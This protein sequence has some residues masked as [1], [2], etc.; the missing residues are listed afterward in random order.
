MDE[1][2]REGTAAGRQRRNHVFGDITME[3]V[4]GAR[5]G[6]LLVALLGVFAAPS[7]AEET[8]VPGDQD[9]RFASDLQRD[10][11]FD[12]ALQ[13]WN[14]FLWKYP[15]HPSAA[16]ASLNLG[17]CQLKTNRWDAAEATLQKVIRKYPQ[18]D[19]LDT[20][21]F[22]LG[23]AQYNLAQAGKPLGY[24]TAGRTFD[25]LIKTFPK[26][27]Y[28][29]QAIFYGGECN[30]AQGR[31]AEAAQAYARLLDEF[32]DSPLVP[33]AM[34]ALG[35]T[36]EES[37]KFKEA[38]AIYDKFIERYPKHPL[39][40]EVVMRRG[41][42]LFGLGQYKAAVEWFA[43]AANRKGF[44]LADHATARQ[45]AALARLK[46]YADAA[47]LYDSIAEKFPESSSKNAAA[48]AG[49]RCYYLV[50]D[51]KNAQRL[52]A[53]AIAAGGNPLP[54]AS[55]W[56]ARSLL[57][58]NKPAEALAAVDHATPTLDDG[59]FA[60]SLAMDRADA[61]YAIPDRRGESVAVY[62]SIAQDHPA[63]PL[64]ET[65]L[66]MAAFTALGQG[67]YAKAG[68][69][70]GALLKRY[71]TGSLATDALALAAEIDLQSGKPVEAEQ[72]Y[73]ELLQRYP[74][75]LR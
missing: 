65:A 37:G 67:D 2:C 11:R 60:A 12:A 71:P 41:E 44:R 50:G 66:Y 32:P 48:L 6:L 33:D 20:T 29:S 72:R 31:V 36:Q 45:A 9:F 18:F 4:R 54:E 64:A 3:W 23:V 51:M 14:E 17:I 39:A 63:D 22:Y 42:T 73:A 57:K 74:S 5:W 58:E 40:V 30:F 53:E 24:A 19:M 13:A 34:Y 43:Y 52:L 35:V 21:L 28:F 16:R 75:T 38:G 1:W 8:A 69:Y 25:A 61:L 70:V 26:S 62:A 55:H 49:G 7:A 47:A 27:K 59:P 10:E 68:D 56:L 15:A 46:Q